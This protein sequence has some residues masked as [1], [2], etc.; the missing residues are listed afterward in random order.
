[1]KLLDPLEIGRPMSDQQPLLQARVRLNCIRSL[2]KIQHPAHAGTRESGHQIVV[3][4]SL[5][6]HTF[7][8]KLAL[9]VSKPGGWRLNPKLRKL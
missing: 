6:Q 1:V 7:E 5:S 8:A 2:K 3:A 9:D 4:V